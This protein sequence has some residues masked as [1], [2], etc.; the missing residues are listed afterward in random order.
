[1]HFYILNKK[2]LLNAG[3]M[4]LRRRNVYCQVRELLVG[5]HFLENVMKNPALAFVIN[6]FKCV[7]LYT[8]YTDLLLLLKFFSDYLSLVNIKFFR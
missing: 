7:N 5:A 3:S 2:L 6:G 4:Q 1:M 8:F